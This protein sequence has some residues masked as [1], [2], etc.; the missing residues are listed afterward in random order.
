MSSVGRVSTN[1]L[2][3]P[4]LASELI[5]LCAFDKDDEGN[6]VAAFDP[7][8]MPDERRATATARLLSLSHVGVIAWKREVNVAVGEY[9]AP[10]VLYEAGEV[11]D[12]D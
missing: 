4:K 11:P 2:P 12:L 9:G 7:R 8:E 10:E 1:Q 3:E 5:V 6:L